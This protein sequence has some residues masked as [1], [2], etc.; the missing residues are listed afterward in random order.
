MMKRNYNISAKDVFRS[1]IS[2]QLNLTIRNNNPADTIIE[3]SGIKIGESD[4]VII[5]GPCS[6]ESK[7][8][9]YQTTGLVKKYG[10]TILRG[11]AFKPRTSPYSFQGLREKGVELLAQVRAEFDIPV[12]SEVMDTQ[13]V[14]LLS[15]QVDILQVGSRNMHN[16]A[17]LEAVGK[18]DK[19]VLLNRGM[20]A[21]IEEFLFA[22]EYIMKQGNENVILCE[23]GIRTFETS[24][25]YTLDISAVSLLKKISHLPVIVDPSHSAGHWWMVQDLAKAA[26][27]A[28]ADGLIIEVHYDP[29]NAVCDGEQSLSPDTFK[30]L[31]HDLIIA[32]NAFGRKISVPIET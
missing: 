2:S 3:V 6:V 18:S 22:A 7:E 25:R 9:L 10:A 26:V 16:Y 30:T 4:I 14:S 20:S 21:T 31:M 1:E 17:L 13:K 11:G 19:P 12:V 24:T 27:A 32:G 23:R 5:A 28:G 29:Q 8:Q 15:D